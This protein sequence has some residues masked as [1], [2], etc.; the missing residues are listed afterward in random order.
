MDLALH[1]NRLD[2]K[3]AVEKQVDPGPGTRNPEP[4]KTSFLKCVLG[5]EGGHSIS[6]G[7]VDEED[8][9][10]GCE[11]GVCEEKKPFACGGEESE[12]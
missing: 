1:S 7:H 5:S 4:G 11:I 10:N 9:G 3:D 8:E 12:L 6:Y 2:W